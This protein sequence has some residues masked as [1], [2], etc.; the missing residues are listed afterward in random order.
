MLEAV[1]SWVLR[2]PLAALGNGTGAWELV[3]GEQQ[4]VDVAVVG[5][6]VVVGE[7]LRH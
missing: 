7:H 6:V 5:L 2:H 4:V 1:D 3:E